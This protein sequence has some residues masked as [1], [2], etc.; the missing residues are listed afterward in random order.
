MKTTQYELNC[1]SDGFAQGGLLTVY[2]DGKLTVRTVIERCK[3]G[4]NGSWY[5]TDDNHNFPRE[6]LPI[7][8]N[9]LVR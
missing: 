9:S 4:M 7:L 2:D 3:P 5:V 1:A 8:L 6:M